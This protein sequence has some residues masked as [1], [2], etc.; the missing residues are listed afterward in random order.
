MKE[1]STRSTESI[2]TAHLLRI[3]GSRT[4]VRT[5][6]T[7]TL[8]GYV[9][10]RSKEIGGGGGAVS[11]VTIQKELGTLSSIWNHWARPIELVPGP[12]PTKGLVYA[13]AR[14][15]PPFSTREQIERQLAHGGL[16]AT[17]AKELRG[18]LFLTMSQVQELLDVVRFRG[19]RPWILVAFCMAACTGAPVRDPAV[20]RR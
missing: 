2:H 14:A 17:E 11:H 15:K 5:I 18:S 8:R 13:K 12:A 1:S 6:T 9:T 10:V 7:E 20:A 19:G 16:S 4:G 3:I